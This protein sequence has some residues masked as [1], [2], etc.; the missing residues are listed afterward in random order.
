MRECSQKRLRFAATCLFGARQVATPEFWRNLSLADLKN[1]FRRQVRRHHPDLELRGDPDLLR[2]KR[3]WFARVKESYEILQDFVENR[4]RHPNPG[5]IPKRQIIAVGGAKG[6]IGKSMLASNL[7]V[8]LN[9]RGFDTVL[10]D[11]DLGGANLHLY[12]GEISLPFTINDY[13]SGGVAALEDLLWPSRYGPMLIGGDG[14][15]LGSANISFAAKMRLVKSLK[16]LPADY[17][18]L[19]LGSNTSFNMLDFFLAADIRL[20]V[21]TCEP[22]AYLEAYNFIKVGLYRCLDRLTVRNDILP[23][24][25]FALKELL[26]EATRPEN[27]GSGKNLRELW[28]R[29][30]QD[31][32]PGNRCAAWWKPTAPVWC[33]TRSALWTEWVR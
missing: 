10:V 20:V 4:H 3:A 11:L 25:S 5:K 12:L 15:R 26:Y 28:Q 2:K 9:A 33:S 27:G 7:G 21:A 18:I 14:S 23:E 32:R 24:N 1:A 29:V 13:L 17:V 22:A 8:F 19:D 6:G 30:Q 31:F 16:A